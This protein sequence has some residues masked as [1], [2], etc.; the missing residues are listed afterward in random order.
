MSNSTLKQSCLEKDLG[1]YISPDLKPGEQCKSAVNKAVQALYQVQRAFLYRDQKVFVNIY[2]QYVRCHLEYASPAWNPYYVSDIDKL[3]NVQKRAVNMVHG[4][5]GL[6]Y[7][8][9]LNK[10]NLE[11]LK[12]RRTKA[13][14]TLVFKIIRGF[15]D[16]EKNMWFNLVNPSERVTRLS[17]CQHNIKAQ[18][19]RTDMRKNF[20]SNRV[21][22]VWNSLPTEV[23]MV[24]SVKSFKNKLKKHSNKRCMNLV[25][26]TFI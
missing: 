19:F 24:E 4:L 14:L 21:V 5:E 7:E 23:K 10:L 2:K 25:K 22:E 17:S 18:K 1:V 20:F 13:D 11:T 12:V 6:S 8:E 26:M 15:C 16:V 9:K 3:E